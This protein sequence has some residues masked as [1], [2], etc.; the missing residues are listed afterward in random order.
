MISEIQIEKLKKEDLKEAISIYDTEYDIN[1]N[2]DKP[3]F[4][5]DK[6]EHN[7]A[8]H[9]IVTKLNSKIVG[10]VTI[11]TNFSIVEECKPFLTVQNF[12]IHKHYRRK[13]IGAQ[14]FEY[15]F[16]YAKNNDYDYILLV[17]ESENKIVQSFCK[18]LGYKEEAGFINLMGR[19]EW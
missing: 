8:Y 10:I 15:I 6:I 4:V 17:T 5:Y 12:I 7:P 14:I 11:V 1:T 18:K 9:C 3:F 19:D 16:N 13:T 2:Y